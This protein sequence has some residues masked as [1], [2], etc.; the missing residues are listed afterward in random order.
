[1]V[2]MRTNKPVNPKTSA[3]CGQSDRNIVLSLVDFE[4]A[5]DENRPICSACFNEY[6]RLSSEIYAKLSHPVTPAKEA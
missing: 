2:H 5:L 1:M 3:A 4:A 6:W